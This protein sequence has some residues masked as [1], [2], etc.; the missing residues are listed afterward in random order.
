MTSDPPA[1]SDAP[2]APPA[3]PS[4]APSAPLRLRFVFAIPVAVSLCLSAA[5]VGTHV[6]WQDSGLYLS[7]VKEFT[8][9]YPHGFMLYLALC[10]AWTLVFG[11]LD[12]TLAV[13]LFSSACAALAAG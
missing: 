4:P 8:V 11:F 7:A 10:K 6:H 9:L 3:P 1:T 13:H 12:F 5:T 2:L